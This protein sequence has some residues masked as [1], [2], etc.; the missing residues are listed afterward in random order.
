MEQ[1][2]EKLS[3]VLQN[4]KNLRS[5]GLMGVVNSEGINIARTRTPGKHGDNVFILN[6]VGRRV[7]QGEYAEIIEIPI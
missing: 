3:E 7:A 4:E 6:P 5:I 1:N 2:T